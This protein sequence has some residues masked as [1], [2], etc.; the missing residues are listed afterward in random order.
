MIMVA[1]DVHGDWA[2]LLSAIK[3]HEP[4]ILLQCGDFGFWPNHKIWYKYMRLVKYGLT[5]DTTIYWCDGN[6]EN[7]EYIG[8]LTQYNEGGGCLVQPGTYYQSRGSILELPDGRI[9][10]F[11]GG[12]VSIDKEY[13]TPGID[14]FPEESIKTYREEALL[15][16]IEARL[17]GRGVDIV[18]SHTCPESFEISGNLLKMKVGDPTRYVLNGILERY[19][20]S[21]WYFG[22]WHQPRHCH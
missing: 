2:R 7:H 4:S 20:P 11:C 6:H 10:L 17:N 18:I 5:E 3:K 12:G 21:L 15:D 1:G 8:K 22:H 19:G 16:S 14:W 13:R 9:V